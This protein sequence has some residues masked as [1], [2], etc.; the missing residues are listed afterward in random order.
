MKTKIKKTI[1]SLNL[2]FE[3]WLYH[4]EAQN[5]EFYENLFSY[6]CKNQKNEI[7]KELQKEMLFTEKY[8]N[9]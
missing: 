6:S 3:N 4:L 5:W 7:I 1:L 9:W 2:Y 8:M